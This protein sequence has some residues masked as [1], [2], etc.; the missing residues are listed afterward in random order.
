MLTRNPATGALTQATDGTGCLTSTPLIGCGTARA[1][2]GSDAV[3]ISTDDR[4]VYITSGISRS[5]A[6]FNRA[7]GSSGLTQP[8][9]ASGCVMS[10]LAVCCAP[11]VES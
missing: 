1:L 4:T 6:M 11:Q 10:V 9:G 8:A 3:A 5:I 7:P 2:R